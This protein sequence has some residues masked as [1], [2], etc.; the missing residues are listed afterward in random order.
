LDPAFPDGFASGRISELRFSTTCRYTKNFKPQMR[1]ESDE[2]T[3][4]LYHFDD[5]EGDIAHDVSGN[6]RHM[7]LKSSKWVCV[8][9]DEP[10]AEPAP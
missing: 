10:V 3:K 5:T 9:S 1:F 8:A 2:H 6:E 7:Q 4:A